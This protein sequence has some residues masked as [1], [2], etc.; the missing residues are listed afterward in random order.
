MNYIIVDLEA[1]CWDQRGLKRQNE[2]IEIGAV[3]VNEH[4]EIESEF[5][6]FVKPHL[7]PELS[8]FCTELTS[9]TQQDVDVAKPFAQ[10][11]TDFLEWINVD[12]PYWV[13]SWGLYDKN[14]FKKD[15]QLHSLSEEWIKN[16]ISIKHQYTDI[17]NLKRHTGMKGALWMENLELDGTHHRGID[18]ARNITKIFLKHLNNWKFE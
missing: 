3:K 14:Q 7:F 6:A 15:C 16:H 5:N 8:D 2:I 11:L 4:G 18:D 9:I 13:C 12:Q 10:V 1:T 17:K